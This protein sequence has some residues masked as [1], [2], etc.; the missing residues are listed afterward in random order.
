MSVKSS[1]FSAESFIVDPIRELPKSGIREFFD[2]VAGRS[3]VISLGVGEPD[4]T[5]PWNVRESAIYSLE[6]GH[7]SYTSNAGTPALRQAI[8]NYLDKYYN[9]SYDPA[10]ECLVTIGVSEALDLAIRA[11]VDPGD[12]VIYTTPCFVSY[13]AEVLMA[14]GVPVPLVTCEQDNF[15]VNP[16]ALRKLIT[17][18]SKIL[19]LNFPCNPTGAVAPESVL[20]EIA[21]IAIENNLIVI[22]DEIYSELVYDDY[23]HISIASLPGMKERTI[24]LHGFSKAFAMTGFRIGYV[25]APASITDAMYKIHQY[26]IMCAPITAQ[27]AALEALKNAH[28]DMLIMRDSYWER[29]N[30]IVHSLRDAGLDCVMP[31]GA[32]YSFPSIKSTGMTSREFAVGLLK[33]ESVAVVPGSAFG[34]GGEGYVRACYATAEDQIIEA[35]KR[36]KRFTAKHKK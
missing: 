4:F 27:E 13:P 18:K 36:I 5:T 8:C 14:R 22:T 28:K 31:Q 11:L 3:D 30:L 20:R 6:A 19:L 33:E 9:V 34:P 32:F 15:S 12:E 21:D 35:L 29:R 17:P 24:F 26:S 16:S 23:K 2:L 25:C 1:T 10:N 7:T